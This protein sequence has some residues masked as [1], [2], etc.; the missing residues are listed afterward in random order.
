MTNLEIILLLVL[1]ISYGVFAIFRT[2]GHILQDEDGE[3]TI[4]YFV[5]IIFSPLILIGRMI[6]GAIKEYK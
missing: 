4:A 6:W 1:W 3:K 5:F 2:H